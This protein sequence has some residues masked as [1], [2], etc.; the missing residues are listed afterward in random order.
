MPM[1]KSFKPADKPILT[2][3]VSNTQNKTIKN[4]KKSLENSS[5]GT[6]THKSKEEEIKERENAKICAD[7]NFVYLKKSL[8]END[9]GFLETLCSELDGDLSD[10]AFEFVK[11][12]FGEE[13]L[14]CF[15]KDL[16]DLKHDLLNSRFYPNQKDMILLKYIFLL[17]Q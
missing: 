11:E 16:E 10:S 3:H 7:S 14:S 2:N 13:W 9:N 17:K 12:N 8:R 1:L 5:D 6:G 4:V 15:K